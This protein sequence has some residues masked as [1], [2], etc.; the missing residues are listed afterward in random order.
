MGE[1]KKIR[2]STQEFERRL[3]DGFLYEFHLYVAGTSSYSLRAVESMNRLCIGALKN[4]CQLYIIDIYES[5]EPAR[6]AQIV[7]V[8]TL[9]RLAPPPVR[10]LVGDL[11]DPGRVLQFLG[12]SLP[13]GEGAV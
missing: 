1:Q 5:P 3:R 10:R 12:V 7:A 9:V 13:A 6:K 11:S 8:P 4:R 2:D